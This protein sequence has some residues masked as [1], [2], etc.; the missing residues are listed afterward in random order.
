MPH[1]KRDTPTGPYIAMLAGAVCIGFSAIFVRLSDVGP[2]ASGFWRMGIAAPFLLM[3]AA[4]HARRAGER[5]PG[6]TRGSLLLGLFFAGDLGSWHWG[7]HWT[8]VANASLLA[9]FSVV[10]VGLWAWIAWR[11]VQGA[12]FLA[13]VAVSLVG[14]ALLVGPGGGW[15]P[16]HLRGDLL[17]L[18]ATLLYSAYLVVLTTERKRSAF[19]PTIAWS[20]AVSAVLLLPLALS[21]AEPFLPASARG[22]AVLLG[23]AL[24][25]QVVGQALIT[26][27]FAHV[28]PVLSTVSLLVQPVVATVLAWILFAER[29]SG[30]RLLGAV[31]VLGGIGAAKASS[32]ASAARPRGA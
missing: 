21:S 13:S 4:L 23:L 10:F 29:L 27:A 15:N 2:F 31:L 16:R 3:A 1:P 12:G 26:Y 28:P 18:L 22:W 24:V 7:I 9:G 25:S 17:T 5:L 19:L 6:P 8:S 20:S 11:Q 14:M 30:A 32:S